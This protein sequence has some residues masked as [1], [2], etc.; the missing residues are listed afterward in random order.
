MDGY[1]DFSVNT[2]AFPKITDLSD[3]LHKSGQK[4]VLIVDGGISADDPANNVYY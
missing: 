4:L 1:K 2:T 3:M